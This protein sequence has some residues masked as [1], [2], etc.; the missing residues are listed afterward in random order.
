MSKKTNAMRILDQ[1][2][3]EYQVIEYDI[4]D[5]NIDGV[6]VAKKVGKPVESVYK[7][8]V[9]VGSSKNY[10]VAMVPVEASVNMKLV[11]KHFGEKKIEMIHVKD[12]MKIT[13]YIR[14]GCSPLGMK[15][16]YK[17]VIDD[18][19]ND[20]DEIV[21]SAGKQGLQIEMSPD[22]LIEILN[23]DVK[24]GVLK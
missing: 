11:A 22:S 6:S 23:C 1:K 4:K 20:L 21:F 9:M 16:A 18:S 15:K 10:Y 5:G 19:I 8:L 3:V 7:T 24:K 12:I 13:G 14:G 2:K 17:T